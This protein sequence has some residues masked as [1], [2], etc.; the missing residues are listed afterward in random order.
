MISADSKN[1]AAWAANRIISTAPTEKLD[2]IS[3]RTEGAPASQPRTWSSRASSNPE[4][5]TTTS[6]P[7]PMHQRRLSMTT[8]GWVKSTTTPQPVSPSRGSP[9]STSAA[10]SRSSAAASARPTSLPI[11]PRAPSTPTLIITRVS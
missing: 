4:V 2:A 9:S 1:R 6:R 3:T 5:P 10:S 7:W 8:P 11:R